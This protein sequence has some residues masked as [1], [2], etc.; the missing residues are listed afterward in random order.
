MQRADAEKPLS[1]RDRKQILEWIKSNNTS[2]KIMALQRLQGKNPKQL[3]PEIG[4]AVQSLLNHEN[5]MVQDMAK[6]AAQKWASAASASGTPTS[7][8]AASRLRT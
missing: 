4:A 5:R 3:D 6:K 2:S 1:D 8:P 7:V